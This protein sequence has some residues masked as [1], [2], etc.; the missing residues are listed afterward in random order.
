MA[1]AQTIG[2]YRILEPLGHGGMGIVYRARHAT[3]E[4]AVALKTVKVSA[5][6]WLDSIRRE[7]DALT[8]IR[9]PGIV[10]IVD[11]GVQHGRPW[12]AMDLLEGE[13]LRRFGQRIWSPYAMPVS[14]RLG[15][16]EQV[17][18][19][20][21]LPLSE[22]MPRSGR[23][24]EDPRPATILGSAGETP[25]AAGELRPVLQLMRRVCATLAFLHGEGFVN[26][27]L[28]PENVLLVGG[29]PVV[30]DFGLTAH[31]PG[32]SG[33]EALEAQPAMSGTLPYMSPEQI[34]GEFVDARSDLYS[35]GCV[36]YEL[37][38]G[39]P[40]FIGPPRSIMTQ[41][42][43]ATP[44]PPSQLVADVPAELERVMLKLLEKGLTDR[45]GFADEVAAVLAEL[46]DDVHRLADYPPPRPYLYR[47][48]LVGRSD[49]VDRLA[50]MRD[51]AAAGSGSFVLL[52]GESGVGK[53]RVAMELTRV[54]PTARMRVVTSEASALS[55]EN[56][57]AVGAAPLQALRPLLQAVADRCQEGGPP[58]TERFLGARRSVLAL[59]EPLLGQVPAHET[60]APPI[61]LAVEASR[62]RLFKYL[63]ETLAAFAQEQPVLWVLDDLGWA[64][65]LS[66]DFL[67]SLSSEYIASTPLFIL[68]TYRSEEATEVVGAISRLP[69]VSHL[70]L[71]RLAPDAVGSMIAD[72]LALPE[73]REGFVDFVTRQA[74]GNPFFVAE[75]VRT[76]VTE[77]VLYRDQANAWQLQ[78][79]K[80]PSGGYE[81]LPLPRSLRELIDH[82]L[83]K[84]TPAAQ[85]VGLAAAVIGREVDLSALRGVAG[86]PEEAAERAIDELLRRQVI[87]QPEPGRVRFAHDKLREV[88]YGQAPAERLRELHA[89]TAVALE[90][91]WREA[92]E[93]SRLWGTL[94]HHFAAGKLAE[95][96]ARYLRLAADHARSTYANGDA[97]RLYR[98]AIDQVNE[99]LLRLASDSVAWHPVVVDLYEAL[100]DL[101]ALTGRRDE[102]RAAYDEALARLAADSRTTRARLLR[103]VGKTWEADH[104]DPDGNALRY[105]A[106]GVDALGPDPCRMSVEHCQE[107]IQL[108]IDRLEAFY[109][110]G[111]VHEMEQTISALRP[112]IEQHGTPAQRVRFFVGRIQ[113]NLR[114]DRYFVSDE[115]LGYGRAAAEACLPDAPERSSAQFAHGFVLLLHKQFEA[116]QVCLD[117]GATLARRAGD[118]PQEARCVTYLAVGSRMRRLV[119]TTAHY[120]ERAV[121]AST[122]AGMR[123]YVAAAQ[124]NQA[125]LALRRGDVDTC[126]ELASRAL[127]TWR[128]LATLVFPFQWTASLPLLQASLLRDD[129]AVAVDCTESLLAP[130][131]QLLPSAA[132]DALQTAREQ[133]TARDPAAFR[134]ALGRALTHLDAAGYH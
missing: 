114:R 27:D 108:H 63:A 127:A 82:R 132:L 55:T 110:M 9:H 25:A 75:H 11:H 4:R 71:P 133:W 81:T 126:I 70:L 30:I 1:S 89:R 17:S 36:L 91:Q 57:G 2:P 88:A 34:R 32:G 23:S 78:Q 20:D 26:C 18:A 58:V 6:R 113:P 84:L 8:R 72:M 3:S 13:S 10:R 47:P 111:R 107:W 54:E 118:V 79:G 80:E 117:E 95:P 98:E 59:Y 125:W 35:V 56:A 42:L 65:E 62:Q 97:I 68:G 52:G 53:T 31:H 69:H 74:E 129:L 105:Y 45:F 94:G 123:E 128:G 86:I 29:Q 48:R 106:L 43:S 46:S 5:P 116:A 51:Q 109:W 22:E 37:V 14:A 41:H 124:G 12:Y 61:P 96:A 83:R 87:E 130:S 33:R 77:R 103:K 112:V 15:V 119:E 50:S 100:A 104:R 76:A 60:M 90:A 134:V 120:T 7:I 121:S 101:L 44:T 64:D 92:P 21:E 38:T 102:A 19:T 28:K 16:A 67:R 40:P 99:L 115:T 122:V 49:V 39:R 85:Q 73:N 131:Q 66:L 24:F 93:P